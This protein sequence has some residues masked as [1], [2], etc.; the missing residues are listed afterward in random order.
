MSGKE[1]GDTAEAPND[2]IS[3]NALDLLKMLPGYSALQPRLVRL[4]LSYEIFICLDVLG[5]LHGCR[6]V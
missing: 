4:Q 3:L 1:I 5:Q 2:G 6:V